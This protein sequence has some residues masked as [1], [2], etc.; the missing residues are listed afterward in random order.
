MATVTPTI[1]KIED[2][3]LSVSWALTSTNVDGAPVHPNMG[4][5]AD[6]VLQV[7]GTWGGATCVL[8]GSNDASTWF[9]LNDLFG[10]AI[11]LTANGM[12]APAEAP[13]YMRPYLSVAGAGATLAAVLSARKLKSG[14]SV[15]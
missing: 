7:T 13:L 3:T 6:R 4:Q 1:D 8:Q 12:A 15:R 10:N 14:Q 9:T 5:F 2:D 11:S